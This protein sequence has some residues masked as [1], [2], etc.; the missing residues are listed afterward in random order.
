MCMCVCVCVCGLKGTEN[1]WDITLTC[2]LLRNY[3]QPLQKAANIRKPGHG[4][5]TRKKIL[6][7]KIPQKQTNQ[8]NKIVFVH[9]KKIVFVIIRKSCLLIT[10]E[11]FPTQEVSSV[12]C[13]FLLSVARLPTV[14]VS[15]FH[16]HN[17]DMSSTQLF[18]AAS[19]RASNSSSQAPPLPWQF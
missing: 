7:Q 2:D 5:N 4:S 11:S 3:I 1:T 13:P 18:T 16:N 6:T 9:H 8:Q 19:A 14:L 12:H 17:K 15:L 10:R